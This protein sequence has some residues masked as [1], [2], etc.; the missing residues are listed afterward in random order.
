MDLSKGHDQQD[1]TLRCVG[2]TAPWRAKFDIVFGN[3]AP[4]VSGASSLIT[5]SVSRCV[6]EIG[7]PYLHGKP[8]AAP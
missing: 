1:S 8:E 5:W 3:S 7:K 6:S 4:V 2:V